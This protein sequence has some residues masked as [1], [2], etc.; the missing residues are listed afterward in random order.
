MANH[1]NQQGIPHKGWELDS[2]ED[3]REDG[4]SVDEAEYECCMM[5]GNERIRFVHVVSHPDVD[6][7]FRVGCVCAMKMTD[8][9]VNPEQHE[10]ELRNKASRRV[11]WTKKNWKLSK[12]G[13][14]Y[15]SVQGHHLLI[16]RDKRTKKYKVKIDDTFGHKTFDTLQKAKVATFNGMEYMKEKGKW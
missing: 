4:Q 3:I 11:N 13:N 7:Q 6:E 14:Y 1:W 16:Y 10:K 2:V 12:S 8:D 5:C 15:L 9:Y